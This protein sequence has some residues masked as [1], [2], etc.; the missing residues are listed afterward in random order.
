MVL[1]EIRHI[2]Y[3]G[4]NKNKN[5]TKNKNKKQNKKQKQKTH[6]KTPNDGAQSQTSRISVVHLVPPGHVMHH[7]CTINERGVRHSQFISER[8]RNC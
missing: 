8:A 1:L 3:C 5:K 2:L 6:Q 7:K 4:Q